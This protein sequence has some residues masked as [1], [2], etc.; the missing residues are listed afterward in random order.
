M[1]LH[2]A[3][4]KITYEF[5]LKHPNYIQQ[6][7]PNINCGQQL[8][9]YSILVLQICPKIDPGPTVKKKQHSSLVTNIVPF[10]RQEPC[11]FHPHVHGVLSTAW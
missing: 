4:F 11:R 1:V 7:C 3:P 8:T 10:T 6:T 2:N 5:H 9:K